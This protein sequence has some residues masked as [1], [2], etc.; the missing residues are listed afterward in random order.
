[1]PFQSNA[2]SSG[3]RSNVQT[4]NRSFL[5][6]ETSVSVCRILPINVKIGFMESAVG[7]F[8]LAVS[9]FKLALDLVELAI[10]LFKLAVDLVKLT[11]G[12]FKLAVDLVK[13]TSS[14]ATV[15][16]NVVLKLLC[17]FVKPVLVCSS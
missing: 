5:S 16:V 1:M 12:P 13:L 4:A 10:G 7:L 11:V 14:S 15:L 17:L 8:E 6:F 3:R 2:A 9:L